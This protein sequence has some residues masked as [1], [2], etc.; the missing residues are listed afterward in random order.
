MSVEP[1]TVSYDAEKKVR[2]PAAVTTS[3][4]LNSAVPWPMMFAAQVQ[5]EGRQ[6]RAHA[7]PPRDGGGENG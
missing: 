7:R 4:V 6:D 3:G 1:S 5:G 2:V